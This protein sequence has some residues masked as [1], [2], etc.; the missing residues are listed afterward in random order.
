MRA[1]GRYGVWG[2]GDR[3]NDPSVDLDTSTSLISHFKDPF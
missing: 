3:T 2:R 1:R